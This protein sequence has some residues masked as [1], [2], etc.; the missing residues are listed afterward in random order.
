MWQGGPGPPQQS[1]LARPAGHVA[2][3][4][5]KV[6]CQVGVQASTVGHFV[7]AMLGSWKKTY[8]NS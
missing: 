8:I 6:D 7:V 1:H 2:N 4:L 5:N 3:E